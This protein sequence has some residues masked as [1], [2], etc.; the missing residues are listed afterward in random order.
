MP[1]TEKKK[2]SK[3]NSPAAATVSSRNG[4]A[5]KQQNGENSSAEER[6]LVVQEQVRSLRRRLWRAIEKGDAV[7]ALRAYNATAKDL[8]K[9]VREE[10]K[11]A[12]EKEDTRKKQEKVRSLLLVAACYK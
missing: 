5:A 1:S 3:G 11:E 10:I 8:R 6:Q 2:S 9:W 7:T 4:T 12:K